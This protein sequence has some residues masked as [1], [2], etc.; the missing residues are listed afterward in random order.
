VNRKN[1]NRALRESLSGSRSSCSGRCRVFTKPPS[2]NV[3]SH[4]E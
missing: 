2:A 3:T 1:A 4:S